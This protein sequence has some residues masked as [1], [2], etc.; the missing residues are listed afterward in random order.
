[1]NPASEI[2]VRWYLEEHGSTDDDIEDLISTL[3]EGCKAREADSLELRDRIL[4]TARETSHEDPWSAIIEL[5]LS[6]HED[7]ER[8]N[9]DLNNLEQLRSISEAIDKMPEGP[10]AR[11]ITTMKIKECIERLDVPAVT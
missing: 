2:V 6:L 7:V 5:A 3:Y 10:L 11:R 9:R 8:A 1:M 4:A